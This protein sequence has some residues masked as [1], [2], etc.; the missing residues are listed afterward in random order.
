MYNILQVARQNRSFVDVINTQSSYYGIVFGAKL[1]ACRLSAMTMTNETGAP[2]HIRAA[3]E[4][5]PSSKV[6]LL[7]APLTIVKRHRKHPP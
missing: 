3:I 4:V 6:H 2:V 5:P 7:L 1:K